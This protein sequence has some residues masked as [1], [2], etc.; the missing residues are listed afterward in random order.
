MASF[1]L[2]SVGRNNDHDLSNF[3]VG[4]IKSEPLDLDLFF[5]FGFGFWILESIDS[6]A[7]VRPTPLSPWR[8]RAP[9]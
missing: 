3:G 2:N 8:P 1:I 4:A 7:P 9:A 6:V 5:A